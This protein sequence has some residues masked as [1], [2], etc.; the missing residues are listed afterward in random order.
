MDSV[1]PK[2]NHR[3]QKSMR[4]VKQKW[5]L[6][7]LPIILFVMLAAQ[8]FYLVSH[9]YLS[10]WLG[11]GYGMFST[12]DYGPS[13]YIRVYALQDNIIQEEIEIPPRLSKLARKVRGLPDDKH[14]FQLA[15]AI[16]NYLNLNLHGFP[17]IRIEVWATKYDAKTLEPAYLKLNSIDHKTSSVK[18]PEQDVS[19]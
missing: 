5:V 13:R 15:R 16:G 18:K 11:G 10:P 19:N 8:H 6:N 14:V 17:V 7:Y 9:E 2:G 12:T 4:F 3:I 1:T